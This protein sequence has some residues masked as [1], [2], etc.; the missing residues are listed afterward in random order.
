MYHALLPIFPESISEGSVYDNVVSESC[1]RT[2]GFL[3]LSDFNQT[4][5]NNRLSQFIQL[6]DKSSKKAVARFIIE[7]YQLPL[8][9]LILSIQTDNVNIKKRVD[10][11]SDINN[12]TKHAIQRGLVETAKITNAWVMTNGIDHAM[13]RL[14][15][16]EL[17]S[18]A[19][20]DDIPCIAFYNIPIVILLL[21]GDFTTLRALSRYLQNGTPVV[22]VEV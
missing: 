1:E 14:I 12:E 19:S 15:G 17:R 7:A 5:N 16:E 10:D 9:D 13:N 2:F 4:A 20:Q 22:V 21:G 6:S 8:P 18:N 3:R 11:N